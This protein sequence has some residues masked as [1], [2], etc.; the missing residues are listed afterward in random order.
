MMPARMMLR[1]SAIF[2]DTD[3]LPKA[4]KKAEVKPF[5]HM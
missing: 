4:V 5:Y 3:P 1:P 2:A